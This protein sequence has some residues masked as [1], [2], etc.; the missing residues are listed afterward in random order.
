MVSQPE[1]T[2]SKNRN[3]YK[4]PFEQW[5]EISWIRT[6]PI[7]E[8]IIS[9]LPFSPDL[10]PLASHPEI[11]KD[12]NS[13]MKALAYQLLGHLRFTNILELSHVNPVTAGLA[14]GRA[15]F[16][17]TY[18]QQSDALRIYCDEGG[19]ALFTEHLAKQVRETYG[20]DQSM[21]GRPRFEIE[22]EKILEDNKT[23]LSPDLIK[24]FFVAISETLITKVLHSLPHDPD[25]DPLVRKV[26]G[27]H[28][29]DEGRHNIYYR[30]LFP[31]IWDSLPC[32]HQEEVGKILPKL[33]CA[34]V[35]PD[36]EFEYRVLRQLGY[37]SEDS[38][39]MLEEIH[40]MSKTCESARKAAAPSLKMF[41]E[42][43]VF[44]IAVV[45][46]TFADH[47]YLVEKN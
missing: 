15:P 1:L 21:I 17:I 16:R 36:L 8:G 30:T 5:D 26:I 25:V 3:G 38:R 39:G 44:Q 35:G 19:H 27:D 37:N 13:W 23:Q 11:A 47:S 43:G 24:L 14:E 2:V 12:R 28:A 31:I 9:G 10:V 33:L 34:F 42:A 20:I 22:L 7:R 4:S 6:K 29:A 32:Y 40:P 41:D 46:Q 45:E 18:Q